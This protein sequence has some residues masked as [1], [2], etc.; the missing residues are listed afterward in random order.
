M[1][2]IHEF[3]EAK[4]GLMI[5]FGLYSLL[6]GYYNG[7]KG[8]NYAEWIQCHQKISIKEMRKLA[9]VFNPIY[10]DSE[11]ICQFAVECGMKYI[12]ITTK[13]HEGFALFKSN[14]DDF[15]A[16]DATP[17][18]KDIIEDLSKACRKYN[19]KLGFYYSQCIDWNEE[20]G[21]GYSSDPSWAAGNSWDNSWDF[22]D[23]SKK[24]YSITFKN[25][26]IPQ[27][28]EI[29]SNY[30]DIFLAWFDMPLDSTSAQGKEIYDLVKELQ[31]NCLVNSRLGHGM[32]DY[33]TLGD[34]EIPNEI[35]EHIDDN[36][37]NNDIWGF[38][39]SPN[40]LYESAC[41]LNCSWG[42]S[43]VIDK[44]KSAEEV[45]NN[46]IKLEKLGIN[47]LINVGLDWLG[48]IPYQAERILK[49][50]SKLYKEKMNGINK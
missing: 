8:P 24:D 12:V 43:T 50:A 25:K 48:R 20:N 2:N 23:R 21:G 14:V 42:H 34:N 10:F 49:E 18:K 31:P 7:N 32:F 22:P 6:A 44:W 26:I 28:R 15:N 3:K 45:C 38:K 11:K 36:I 37:D 17:Y 13:H 33:V 29:M 19:L 46:R 41:T 40:G 47:Y 27:I 1:N 5:H 9:S 35:P 16:C 4:Y 30:G 39:K